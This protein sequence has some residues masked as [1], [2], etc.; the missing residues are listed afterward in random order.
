MLIHPTNI[1]VPPNGIIL[2]NILCLPLT[3]ATYIGSTNNSWPAINDPAAIL[4]GSE[5]TAIIEAVKNPTP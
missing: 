5:G 4:S 3:A 1:A 2:L